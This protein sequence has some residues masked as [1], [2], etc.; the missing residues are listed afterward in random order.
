MI[1]LFGIIWQIEISHDEDKMED[2]IY[3]LPEES[4]D[5]ETKLPPFQAQNL[6]KLIAI[7]RNVLFMV[8]LKIFED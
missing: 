1:R 6:E 2:Q 8:I 4:I 3:V 7:K 5:R